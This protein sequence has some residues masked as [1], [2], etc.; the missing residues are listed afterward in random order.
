REDAPLGKKRDPTTVRADRGSDVDVA[1]KALRLQ[2][3]AANLGRWSGRGKDGLIGAADGRLPV[4]RQFLRLEAEHALDR[5]VW[6]AGGRRHREHPP[7][8]LVA[9]APTDVRP[10]RLA[11]AVRK[12]LRIVEVVDAR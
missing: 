1:A 12:I 4:G 9:V 8:H 10:E 3:D 6:I 7:N 11:P 5:D 2:H